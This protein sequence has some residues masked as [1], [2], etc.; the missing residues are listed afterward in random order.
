[1][2]NTM[3]III[4]GII[5]IGE[6]SLKAYKKKRER[7]PSQIIPSG[8]WDYPLNYKYL[9]NKLNIIKNF[10]LYILYV[11]FAFGELIG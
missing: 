8:F 4:N 2:L 3:L 7:N 1:M 10:F 11:L 6:S 9:I 5:K